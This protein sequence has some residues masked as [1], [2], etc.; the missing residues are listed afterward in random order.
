MAEKKEWKSEVST[1]LKHYGHRNWIVVADAAYPEQ[2]N[3]AI[4]TFSIEAS[5]LEAVEFVNNLV[6]K[7]SHVDANIFIDRELAFVPEKNARGVEKYR[8]ELDKIIDS[9]SVQTILHEDII[10]KLDESANLFK[11]LILKTDLTIP[12]SSVFFQL[13][14][15]YWD[16]ESENELRE[17]ISTTK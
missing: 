10:K 14:C 6:E 7:A 5:Q 8:K 13:E 1:I 11:V 2:S 12:Y 15:G 16:S 4:K 3:I 17:M 9:N